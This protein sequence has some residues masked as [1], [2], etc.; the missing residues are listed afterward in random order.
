MGLFIYM[1][2]NNTFPKK[3]HLCGEIRTG[4][5]FAEGSAFIVYPVRVVYKVVDEKCDANV[6][7]MVSVPK[8]RFKHAVDRNRI[9]RLLREAYRL[10][11]QDFVALVKEKELYLHIAFNYVSDAEMEFAIIN[12]KINLALQKISR[13]IDLQA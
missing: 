9:K 3:E 6:R 5:L 11:K 10:N 13:K 8:K 12:E 1:S 7:V 2:I 4:K